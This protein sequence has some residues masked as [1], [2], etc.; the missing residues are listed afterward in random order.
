MKKILTRTGDSL[1]MQHT[2]RAERFPI[3]VL[4][5]NVRSLYNV[6]SIFRT[7]DAAR[8][9]RVYLCGFT[10][11]PPRNEISKTALGAQDTVP[12]EYSETSLDVIR[13]LKD[14][15]VTIAAVEH[16]SESRSIWKAE[17]KY[18]V[19]FLFGYEVEGIDQRTL[20]LCDMSI[21][22]PMFGFKGS[23]NVSVACGIVVF[24]ALRRCL[25]CSGQQRI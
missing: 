15:E 13:K 17:W 25:G 20:E 18:P 19:C 9:E 4:V 8:V 22:I 16:T 1:N 12:W 6:G 10:G 5:E 21:Q 23:L 11:T 7:C 2:S 24:E 14:R 3:F